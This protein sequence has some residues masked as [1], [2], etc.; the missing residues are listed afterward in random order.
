MDAPK[1]GDLV[2]VDVGGPPLDGIV[3]DVPSHTK[4]V[5]AVVDRQRGPSFRTVKADA[6]A[7][8]AEEGA[9]DPAL[10]Q[11]MR[12][13]PLPSHGAARAGSGIG[14]GRSGHSRAT[15]HRT[16]GK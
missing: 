15:G 10:R 3:F 1:P 14:Q 7:E 9:A 12:R 4:I 16:T 13:T 8:R 6:L 5:V 11:L 2:K